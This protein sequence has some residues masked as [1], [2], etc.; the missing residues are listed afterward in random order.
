MEGSALWVEGDKAVL[1]IK[2]RG[3]L[4]ALFAAQTQISIINFCKEV[5]GVSGVVV[6]N[7]AVG[8]FLLFG[9]KIE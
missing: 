4:G 2:N 8:F 9:K 7:A 3:N 5:V 1:M 6:L